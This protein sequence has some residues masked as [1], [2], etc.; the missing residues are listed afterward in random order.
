MLGVQINLSTETFEL[1]EKTN[2]VLSSC[3][4]LEIHTGPDRKGDSSRKHKML[5]RF[6]FADGQTPFTLVCC[7][8]AFGL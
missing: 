6:Q 2:V 5:V 7:G 8:R 3:G 1:T 4:L